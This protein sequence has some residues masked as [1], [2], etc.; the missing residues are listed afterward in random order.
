[1]SDITFFVLAGTL[2]LWI[3]G[4]VKSCEGCFFNNFT[5][6]I[7]RFKFRALL[8]KRNSFG[9]FACFRFKGADSVPI[10]FASMFLWR[11]Y[12]LLS[13]DPRIRL[14]PRN[15]F[16]VDSRAKILLAKCLW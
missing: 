8:S 1:M 6:S 5:Q 11:L 12:I 15:S 10:Y 13:P 3:T 2:E 9:K 16:P 14:I 4:V 7:Y